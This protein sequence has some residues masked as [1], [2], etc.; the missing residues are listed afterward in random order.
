MRVLIIGDF[1]IPDRKKEIGLEIER[2]I[3]RESKKTGIDFLACTGD[4]T[5]ADMLEPVLSSWCSDY[6]VVQG[7][8][9]YDLRNAKGFPR[10]IV[11]DT[12]KYLLGTDVIKIGITHGHQVN[13]RGDRSSLSE[14]AQEYGVHVLISGHTHAPSAV[15]HRRVDDGK[16]ILLLNPG[17]ATGAWSFV[18]S[19]TPSYILLDI[20]ATK[21]GL[22]VTVTIHE[23][24]DD[25]ETKIGENHVFLG[26]TFVK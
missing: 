22:E 16:Q 21:H 20:M 14:I 9:D 19:M 2:S 5:K 11:F 6:A 13:P 15:L 8:M 25:K 10:K 23:F 3:A 24:V 1:H 12:A 26:G 7:N 17:S 4:L 18:A